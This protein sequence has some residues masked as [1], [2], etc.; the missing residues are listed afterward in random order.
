[1]GGNGLNIESVAA[2]IYSARPSEGMSDEFKRGADS[3]RWEVAYFLASK[4]EN[5][6]PNFNVRAFLKACGF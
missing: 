5:E 4:Y 3:A 2:A 6:D 1:V